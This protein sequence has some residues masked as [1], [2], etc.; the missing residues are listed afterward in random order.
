MSDEY[1]QYV[2]IS[3]TDGRNTVESIINDLAKKCDKGQVEFGVDVQVERV[4]IDQIKD[5][6]DY[7]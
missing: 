3:S 7:E 4:T 2:R 1:T 5:S 6:E